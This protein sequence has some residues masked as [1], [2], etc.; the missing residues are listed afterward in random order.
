MI[1]DVWDKM[2]GVYER[3][4]RLLLMVPFAG[5]WREVVGKLDPLV[6]RKS[7]FVERVA[8]SRLNKSLLQE[9]SRGLRRYLVTCLSQILKD[10]IR[11]VLL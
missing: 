6:R 4:C 5:R 2:L 1:V 7:T 11:V 9:A 3:I 8:I 10:F